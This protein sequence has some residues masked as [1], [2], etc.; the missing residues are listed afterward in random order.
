ME[1]YFGNKKKSGKAFK[2]VIKLGKFDFSYCEKSIF[3]AKFKN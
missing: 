3:S 2:T 1:I